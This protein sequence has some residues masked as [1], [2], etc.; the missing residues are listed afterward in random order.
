VR[1]SAQSWRELLVNLKARGLQV[2]PNLAVANGT[3]SFW[4]AVDEVFPG[5]RHQWCWLHKTA[6]IHPQQGPES[7]PKGLEDILTMAMSGAAIWLLIRAGRSFASRSILAA[8]QKK[9]RR[10]SAFLTLSAG[11]QR[12]SQRGY[13]ILLLHYVVM[14][15]LSLLFQKIDIALKNQ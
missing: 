4:K 13:A 14:K 9:A 3:L 15:Q 10:I 5:T 12:Y 1:E 8:V 2:G 7:V 11:F 6:N